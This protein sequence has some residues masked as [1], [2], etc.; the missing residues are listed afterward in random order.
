MGRYF[1]HLRNESRLDPD[2]YGVELPD[3]DAAYAEAVKGAR[4]M[5][6]DAALSGRDVSKRSFEVM[7]A[8]G[9]SAF[10]FPFS[11]AREDANRHSRH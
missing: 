8:N 6:A 11:L 4:S 1:F 3:A 5:M 9:H 10:T 7:D 2:E